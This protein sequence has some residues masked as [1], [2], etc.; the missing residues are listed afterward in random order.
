MAFREGGVPTSPAS[1][2]EFLFLLLFLF[3]FPFGSERLVGEGA[4]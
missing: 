4:A 1:K 3:L 2:F